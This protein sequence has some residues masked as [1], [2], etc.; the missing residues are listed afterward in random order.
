MLAEQSFHAELDAI[1][2]LSIEIESKH[3]NPDIKQLNQELNKLKT[4]YE[5]Q[6][7]AQ[8]NAMI[9]SRAERKAQRKNSQLNGE[10]YHK[11]LDAL[12]QQSVAEKNTLKYLKLEWEH[13]IARV[14]SV[15][16]ALTDELETLRTERKRLS[17]QLQNKLFSQY[18]FLNGRG[19]N[20]SLQSIFAKTNRN[21][22]C[23]RWR[24]RCAKTSSFA[25]KNIYQPLAF[26]EFWW[27]ASPKSE[28]RQH[29]QFYPS[30]HSKC[31]PILGHMLEGLNV[32]ENPL[33][34]SWAKDKPLD[35]IFEDE[36]MVVV[37]KPLD[38]C[39][40]RGKP[41]KILLIL[42]FKRF[43]LMQRAPL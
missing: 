17:N 11:L 1:T 27:G 25:Y 18:Q 19:E 8:R 15:L 36:A 3:N 22:T 9:V 6:E 20:A 41:L 34:E 10:D 38:C 4:D 43:T 14:T 31:Q 13:K 7:T 37:N 26:A 39:P 5:E 42:A 32:D 24:M 2:Q 33:E 29:G 30:C 40:C 21:T 12:A 35:I 23:R 28:I 16:A